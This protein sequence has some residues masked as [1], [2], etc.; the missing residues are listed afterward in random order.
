MSEQLNKRERDALVSLMRVSSP[1]AIHE[2]EAERHGLLREFLICKHAKLIQ[3]AG[4]ECSVRADEWL[5]S[6]AGHAALAPPA[7]VDGVK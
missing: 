5:E 3:S 4:Y 6:A 2:H 1:R 7:P